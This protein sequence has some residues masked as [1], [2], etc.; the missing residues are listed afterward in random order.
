MSTENRDEQGK[1]DLGQGAEPQESKEPGKPNDQR[2]GQQSIAGEGHRA[3]DLLLENDSANPS[4]EELEKLEKLQKYFHLERKTPVAN[5]ILWANVAAFTAMVVTTGIDS[6]LLP[7]V[8]SLLRWGALEGTKT[9]SGEYW[10]ILT[11]MFLHV[12]I[13]H[14]ALNM[15]VFWFVGPLVERLFG[16]SKFS[17]V[18]FLAGAGG[19]LNT[20][21]FTPLKVCAGASGA[22]FG[23][24]G[25]LLAFF[26]THKQDFPPEMFKQKMRG[27]LTFLL[28]NIAF[29]LL[30]PSI[31]TAAHLGGL[32]VGYLAGIALVPKNPTDARWHWRDFL[33]L[34][35]LVSACAGIFYF[36]KTGYLDFNGELSLVRAVTLMNS[37]KTRDALTVINRRIESEPNDIRALLMRA[38]AYRAL[39]ECPKAIADCDKVLADDH[40]SV[41]ALIA[42]SQCY[43]KMYELNKALDDLNRAAKL[44]PESAAIYAS[45]GSIEFSQGHYAEA[46][47]DETKA[48]QLKPQLT[49]LY[50]SRAYA[51]FAN[52]DRDGAIADD[53]EYLKAVGWNEEHSPY[54]V[55]IQALSFEENGNKDEAKRILDEGIGK[56][57][58]EWPYPVIQ[59]LREDIS[60][61][62]LLKLATDND[63]MTEAQEY[64]GLN[65][66]AQGKQEVAR[67][68]YEWVV[69][70]GNKGFFEY[71][72]AEAG[73]KGLQK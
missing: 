49:M 46:I 14:L 30:N 26:Q 69:Q 6:I 64:I 31:G 45:R 18:Y 27:L 12:G 2:D 22:I 72:L 25:A 40:D 54:A 65:L 61:E 71:G 1:N 43:E 17:F 44:R 33:R 63:K 10:R 55:I 37:G 7:S 52:G 57:K 67:V 39:D 20:L 23:I 53:R 36:A 13:L 32:V 9:F 50:N 11:S 35:V 68:Y 56:L 48:L 73:L 59:Y 41:P 5:F 15:Y 29:G 42:R 66:S 8:D 21:L 3:E 47:E 62:E 70:H 19:G 58:K 16:S 51:K 60:A 38:A 24:F 4:P 34:A 28:I